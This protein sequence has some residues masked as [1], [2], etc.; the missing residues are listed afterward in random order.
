[1]R[2]LLAEHQNI[3]SG[4]PDFFLALVRNA[5]VSGMAM[6]SWRKAKRKGRSK[7]KNSVRVAGQ[8]WGYPAW[9]RD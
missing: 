8:R 2:S 4:L 5:K 7:G 1:M 9:G 3:M 6:F